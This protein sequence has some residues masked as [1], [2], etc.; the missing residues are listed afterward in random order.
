MSGKKGLDDVAHFGHE[1]FVD[2]AIGEKPPVGVWVAG[3]AICRDCM[4]AAEEIAMRR[5]FIDPISLEP[6]RER[7]IVCCRCGSPVPAGP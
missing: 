4:S 1:T 5:G 2:P 7:E 3:E 6:G